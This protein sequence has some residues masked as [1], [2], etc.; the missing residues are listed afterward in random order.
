MCLSCDEQ[1]YE[2]YLTEI[3]GTFKVG[4]C[5]FDAGKILHELDEIAFN[6][7]ML[8]Q[9][10]TCKKEDIVLNKLR[11]ILLLHKEDND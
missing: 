7:G 10:C 11:T 1:E 4:C 9:T 6:C 5:E 3:Y 2:D 8:E